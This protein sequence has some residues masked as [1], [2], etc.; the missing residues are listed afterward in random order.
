MEDNRYFWFEEPCPYWE[1]EWTAEVAAALKMN[2]AGGEQDN[3]LAQWRRMIRMNAV[4]ILQ[5]DLCYIGGLHP[6]LAR[7]EDGPEGG[8][9][10]RAALVPP[11]AGDALLAALHGRHPQR[12]AVRRVQHR[13]GR[14]R[15]ARPSTARR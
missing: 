13:R 2:V 9:A 12:G 4:D 3:D 5:P 11:V 14:E 10:G 1:L 8:Q 15:R 6:R 7:G